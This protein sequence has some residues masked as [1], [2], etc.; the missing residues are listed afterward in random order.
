M[1]RTKR[2]AK[3]LKADLI[4]RATG[5]GKEPEI[6]TLVPLT[7]L[8]LTKALN[9]YSGEQ[10][11]HDDYKKWGVA[12]IM[13]NRPDLTQAAADSKSHSYVSYGPIFRML[14]R[15][16]VPSDS[17]KQHVERF[18]SDLM[19]SANDDVEEEEKKAPVRRR[20]RLNAIMQAF[21]NELDQVLLN[22]WKSKDGIT[23]EIDPNHDPAPV[24]ARCQEALDHFTVDGEQQ[25][26]PHMKKWFKAVIEKLSG[27]QKIT[28]VRKTTKRRARKVNPGKMVA[29]VKFLRKWEEGN[30]E[31]RSPVDMVGK[32]KVYL[33]DT[34]YKR[35]TRLVC[36][37]ASGF[38]IK[39]T[40]IQ[41][42]DPDKSKVAFL[43]GPEKLLTQGMGIRALDQVMNSTKSKRQQE[44]KGR[45]NEHTIIMNVS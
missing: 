37:E 44:P 27:I 1:A 36:G 40:T 20:P 32:Q 21:D 15:G 18:L 2:V 19:V 11:T 34:K 22:G 4:A 26:P 39:G 28:R 30:I 13:Q 38:V 43:R 6:N 33:Y 16:M 23:F 8:E 7:N 10:Y 45:I 24:I 41:N 3:G 29:K 5:K 31:S 35:M 12:W 14:S 42:F 25:Y 17:I 9:S